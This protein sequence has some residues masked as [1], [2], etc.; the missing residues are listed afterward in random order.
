MPGHLATVDWL[1]LIAYVLFALGV[2]VAFARRASANVDE[3][4][5]S[6]RSLPWWIAGTSMVATSFAADTPLLIS[7]WVRDEGIWK[8][9]VWWCLMINGAL[10]IFLFARWWRRAGVM[11]KAQLVELRFFGGLTLSEAAQVVDISRA[12]AARDWEAARVWL[13]GELDG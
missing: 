8:N 5:L 11:T 6:G 10:Q 12:T 7:G 2:G 9:W 1:I 13:S 4:F 3:Y